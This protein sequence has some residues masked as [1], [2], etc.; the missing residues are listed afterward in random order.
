MLFVMV[1][2]TCFLETLERVQ[3]QISKFKNEFEARVVSVYPLTEAQKSV[4]VT[5]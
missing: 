1:M 2:Q 4:S 5:W 3:L